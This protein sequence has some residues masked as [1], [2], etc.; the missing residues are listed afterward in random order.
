MSQSLQQA[1]HFFEGNVLRVF[2][3]DGEP[4]FVAADVCRVLE[5][6][7]ASMAIRGLDD[8]EKDALNIPD[9]IGRL[10]TATIVN[11]AG[12]YSLVL[13]SRKPEAKRFK[14]WVTHEVLPSIRKTGSYGAPALDL[15]NPAQLARVAAQLAELTQELQGKVAE[16]APKAHWY[17]A[18]ANADGCYG[19][20]NAGRVLQQKPRKFTDW[21]RMSGYLHREGGAL[22]PNAAHAS[23]GIFVVRAVKK[24]TESGEEKAYHQTYITPTGL[25]YF[26]QKLGVSLAAEG[27]AA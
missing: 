23:K 16:L 24:T 21:L 3:R 5:H 15:R 8:D 2:M 13:S 7:N 12:L 22:V 17:D 6:S 11:E 18:F 9:P 4:W 20:M 27:A 26:A 25:Q 10:Q 14:R 1:S 19:L